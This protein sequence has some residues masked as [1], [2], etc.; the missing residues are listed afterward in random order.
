MSAGWMQSDDQSDG[1]GDGAVWV[2]FCQS[3][4][5]YIG[6]PPKYTPA[7]ESITINT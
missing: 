2:V 6:N 1:D 4:A 3:G 7:D 5:F